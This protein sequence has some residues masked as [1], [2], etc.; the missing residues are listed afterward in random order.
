MYVF[1]IHTQ[2]WIRTRF[3]LRSPLLFLLIIYPLPTLSRCSPCR[4][5]HLFH[6][7]QF[8]NVYFLFGLSLNIFNTSSHYCKKWET[9]DIPRSGSSLERRLRLKTL[10]DLIFGDLRVW[11]GKFES[12]RGLFL[13]FLNPD[14]L[15]SFWRV[16]GCW[17]KYFNCDLFDVGIRSVSEVRWT[18]PKIPLSS[19]FENMPELLS[20]SLT[21]SKNGVLLLRCHLL[22]G[23]AV[24][25]FSCWPSVCSS[26]AAL[27]WPG[28]NSR[29][30][31]GWLVLFVIV[32]LHFSTWLLQQNRI[33]FCNE[34][35][36]TS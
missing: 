14:L 3:C 24:S 10:K 31:R 9:S 30:P 26:Q 19:A 25:W 21:K 28:P 20:S 11:I 23:S 33:S 29:C 27:L 17:L 1:Q 34:L 13:Q 7:S 32:F 36:G 12:S 2:A 8:N 5:F 6:F 18:R 35:G 4:F 16:V 22:F 15:Q